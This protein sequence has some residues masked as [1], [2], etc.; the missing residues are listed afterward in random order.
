MR[1]GAGV[2]WAVALMALPFFLQLLGFGS[3]ALGGGL[4]G[5]LFRG[6]E[7]PLAL[8]GAGFWYALV[9]MMLLLGQLGYA[10]ILALAGF[11][12]LPPAWLGSVYRIGLYYAVGMALLFV[13]TRTTG[14][15]VPAAQ[16]WVWGEAAVVDP[17]GLLGVGLTLAAGGV[18]W[19]ISRPLSHDP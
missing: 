8:Q 6:R 9:F 18:L 19:V 14:L 1:Q 4:C 17:L 12:E 13:V 15:P 7:T 16:G 3:T 11:L 2:R 10:G 5:E